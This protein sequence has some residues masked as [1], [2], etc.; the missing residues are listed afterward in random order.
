M[1]SGTNRAV[2]VRDLFSGDGPFSSLAED[3]VAQRCSHCGVPTDE[4]VRFHDRGL[5]CPP[6]W[7]LVHS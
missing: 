2:L 5:F 4:D 6:C 7:S 1:K 3:Y